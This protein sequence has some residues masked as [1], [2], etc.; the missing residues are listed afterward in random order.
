VRTRLASAI[1]R[2]ALAAL[3][4]PFALDWRSPVLVSVRPLAL[5]CLIGV[6]LALLVAGIVAIRHSRHP[7]L[8]ALDGLA[9]LA[10]AV[11]LVSTATLEVRFHL[12]RHQVLNADTAALEKL[13]H[14]LVVGYGDLDEVHAASS[15][16]RR[17]GSR[18]IR[19]AATS[20]GFLRRFRGRRASPTSSRATRIAPK[21]SQRCGSSGASRAAPL[22]A[23]AS[24]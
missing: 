9:L 18:R 23:W 2:L 6:P 3:L 16:C 21:A 17:C 4:L 22:R 14:H 13:G 10:A 11:A 24:T 8:R 20:R 5:A 12:M 1:L 7:M 15:T 19:R